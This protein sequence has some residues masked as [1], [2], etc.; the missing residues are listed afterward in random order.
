MALTLFENITEELTDH[1]KNVLV[2]ML[3][4]TMEYT[5]ENKRIKGKSISAWFKASGENVSE[6]RIRKMVNYIR[7]TNKMAP[8]V[9]I[10]ASDGYYITKDVHVVEKQID[11]IQ[12][13]IDSQAAVID[14]MKAQLLNLKRSA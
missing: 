8:Y 3:I 5:G 2:P 9:L 1:E 14:S 4:S 12:G 10:G 11:S 13:R 7:V 6:A